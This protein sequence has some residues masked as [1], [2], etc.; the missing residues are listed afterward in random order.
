[1]VA[2]ILI[3]IPVIMPVSM[4]GTMIS[5]APKNRMKIAVIMTKATIIPIAM[6]AIMAKNIF[7]SEGVKNKQASDTAAPIVVTDKISPIM[8]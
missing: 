8:K 6:P 5:M 1:M 4:V 7:Q 2:A 3:N